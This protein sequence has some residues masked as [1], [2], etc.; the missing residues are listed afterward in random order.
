MKGYYNDPEATSA[1]IK[2]VGFIAVICCCSS[3]W[4]F[5]N[6]RPVQGCYYKRRKNISSVEVEGLLGFTTRLFWKL[7]WLVCRTKNGV[8]PMH[9]S[10]FKREEVLPRMN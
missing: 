9:L 6:K 5:G 10:S 2:M 7:Q 1:A 8:R 3:R 4:L